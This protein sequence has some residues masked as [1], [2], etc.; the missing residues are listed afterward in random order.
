[1]SKSSLIQEIKAW[2][3][4]PIQW[5]HSSDKHIFSTSIN[6]NNVLLRLNDF[7]AEPLCSIIVDNREFVMEEFPTTWKLPTDA[8]N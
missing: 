1:M 6:G 2:R 7:P 5:Q 3:K 8:N 4:Q